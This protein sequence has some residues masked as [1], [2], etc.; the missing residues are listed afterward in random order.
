MAVTRDQASRLLSESE[1]ALFGD[2]RNPALRALSP[3]ELTRRIERTRKLRD[4][5]RDLL[6]R[7]KLATRGRTGSKGGVT[8]TANE[9]TARKGEVL[10]DILQRFEDRL[11]TVQGAEQTESP[12]SSAG[13]AIGRK[14]AA[15]RAG[16]TS[17][18]KSEAA[19]TQSPRVS[20]GDGKSDITKDR[21]AKR[22]ADTR[23]DRK[24]A[25]AAAGASAAGRSTRRR[26]Q[27]VSPDE[28]LANTR[29]LLEA[30]QQRDRETP[31]YRMLEAQA[32]GRRAEPE[33]GFQSESARAR[34]QELHAGEVR[35]DPIHGSISTRDRQSQGKRDRR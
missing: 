26:K 18:R 34:A 14:T 8:G 35:L 30:K 23:G 20:R 22:R 15:A 11:G 31:A 19:A 27:A 13:R 33:S 12:R 7:Q 32:E 28:A 29:Q 2:S 4:K 1:M 16:K 5:S 3:R 6:Q 10:D 24:A 9:R 25:T 17:S 21:L